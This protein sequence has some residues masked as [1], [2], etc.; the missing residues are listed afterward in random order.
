MNRRIRPVARCI[1]LAAALAAAA[2]AFAEPLGRLFFTP[3][4]RAAL[5]RQ[6]QLNIQETRTVQGG[7]L[8]LDG[9]VRSSSG[10]STVWVNGQAQH[11][12]NRSAGVAVV[13][14]RRDAAHARLSAG[15][16]APAELK[17]GESVNRAT[18]ET[19]DPLNGGRVGRGDG[20]ER[21]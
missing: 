12:R 17:V 20:A 4:R 3:E 8:R 1:A 6:R 9:I 10:H 16:D 11:V 7:S 13:L 5:E 14:P 19:N 2:P 21:R 18:H 15:E